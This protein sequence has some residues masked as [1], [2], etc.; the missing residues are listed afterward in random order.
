[1]NFDELKRHIEDQGCTFEKVFEG[2]FLVK[3]CI[4]AQCCYVEDLEFYSIPT[5]AN[6]FHELNIAPHPSIE[7]FIHVYRTFRKGLD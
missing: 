5:L 4:N 6:Y 1:M 3:N 2:V 7:D